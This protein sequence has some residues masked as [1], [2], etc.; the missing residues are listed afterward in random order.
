MAAR[1]QRFRRNQAREAKHAEQ[2]KDIAAHHIADGN[3]PLPS[4]G[5]HHRGHHLRQGGA[6]SNDGQADNSLANP[7]GAGD[8]HGT[9]HQPARAQD[10]ERQP[11]DNQ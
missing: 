5:G 9:L 6:G 4:Q 8:G 1:D 7:Q 3:V 2:V 11:H 10:Q